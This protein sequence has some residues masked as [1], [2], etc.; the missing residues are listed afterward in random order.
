MKGRKSLK[1]KTSMKRKSPVRRR[2]VKKTSTKRKSP[3]RRRRS[4]KKVSVKRKSPVRRRHRS[5]K[6]ISMKRKSPIRRKSVKRK[7][8]KGGKQKN[9]DKKIAQEIINQEQKG[10]EEKLVGLCDSY[11][12]NTE[13]EEQYQKMKT[14]K[15]KDPKVAKY[16]AI[17]VCKNSAL[18]TIGAKSPI[19]KKQMKYPTKPWWQ[20]W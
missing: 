3:A 14:R 18:A 13:F 11:F 16:E 9:L 4:V 15:D 7:S 10:N 19:K 20:F 8:Q 5:V 2:S 17:N 6:K 1:K 12:K